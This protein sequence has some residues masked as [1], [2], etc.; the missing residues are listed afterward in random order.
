MNLL[1]FLV[2]LIMPIF[3]NSASPSAISPAESLSVGTNPNILP[4]NMTAKN[5]PRNPGFKNTVLHGLRL[6]QQYSHSRYQLQILGVRNRGQ[7]TRGNAGLS[8]LGSRTPH[9]TAVVA[10]GEWSEDIKSP[11]AKTMVCTKDTMCWYLNRFKQ[12]QVVFEV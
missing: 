2:V 11:K 1:H 10:T 3:S 7:G 8:D 6:A 4:P 5:D 12:F 9:E